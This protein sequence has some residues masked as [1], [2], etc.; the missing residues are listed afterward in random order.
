MH[1]VQELEAI[2]PTLNS[3]FAASL[4]EQSK[5]R[6]LSDK[7]M[8]WVDKL[9]AEASALKPEA[10][11]VGDLS[12]ITA[13]FDKAKQHLKFPAIVMSVPAANMTVRINVAGVQA[14]QPGSLNVAS[15]EKPAF[16]G[17]RTW[18]GRV[19]VGGLYVPSNSAG[20]H[21]AAITERLIAFAKDPAGI[22]AEH[23]RLTGRCCF[24]NLH[25][26]D[27]RST[28]V[29]YGKTCAKNYGLMW[30]TK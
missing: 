13:L 7:Q 6:T 23:G 1:T 18:Y 3:T 29:G 22:A 10:A 28:A 16:D 8:F 21:T 9:V 17:Q 19:T 12:G 14:K 4:V 26:S 30:G 11:N 5:R 20:T 27:E 2:L 25:L 24:C 15:G